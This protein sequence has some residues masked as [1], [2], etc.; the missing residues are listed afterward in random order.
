MVPSE[1]ISAWKLIRGLSALF[2]FGPW[3]SESVD[4]GGYPKRPFKQERGNLKGQA[5][6]LE[7]GEEIPA[8]RERGNVV[9]FV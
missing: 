1:P 9:F 5:V 7:G 6:F 3:Q 4:C 8:F 2:G